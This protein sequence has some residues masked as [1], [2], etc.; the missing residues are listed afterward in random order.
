M[1]W[2]QDNFVGVKFDKRWKWLLLPGVVM[3]WVQYMFPSGGM[4]AVA[5]TSRRV[6][7]PVMTAV[8][9]AAFYMV[10]LFLIIQVVVS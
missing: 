1:R 5:S 3:L 6:R 4:S 9:S 2:D 7:S 8:Y 10:A